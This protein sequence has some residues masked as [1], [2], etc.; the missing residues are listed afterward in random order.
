M[1]VENPQPTAPT[2]A[3]ASLET[4][5]RKQRNPASSA[6]KIVN[7]HEKVQDSARGRARPRKV[8]GWKIP[9][10]ADARSGPPARTNRFQKGKRPLAAASRT[11]AR[12]GMFANARSE[13]IGF[14]GGAISPEAGR[15]GTC[16]V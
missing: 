8:A 15:H 2:R 1:Y 6:R 5:S 13:R 4:K 3:A 9:A 12:H 14:A 7:V 16:A 10:W 11:A